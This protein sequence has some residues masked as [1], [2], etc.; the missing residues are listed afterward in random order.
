[1]ANC[2]IALMAKETECAEEAGMRV[3]ATNGGHK[4]IVGVLRCMSD[5]GTK[6][7]IAFIYYRYIYKKYI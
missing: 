7:P 6:A 1:M 5:R 2:I 4:Y 3:W